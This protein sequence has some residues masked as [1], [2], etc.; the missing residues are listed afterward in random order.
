MFLTSRWMFYY[1]VE[2]DRFSGG[3]VMV[4]SVVATKPAQS[5]LKAIWQLDGTL[6]RNMSL[7]RLSTSLSTS[8]TYFFNK[9]TPGVI[10]GDAQWT[11]FTK[12]IS[13]RYLDPIQSRSLSNRVCTCVWQVKS[14][15]SNTSI[16]IRDSS[17]FASDTPG[18]VA[19]HF[20]GTNK[21]CNGYA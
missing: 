15:H 3:I 6:F 10:R 13:T 8:T 12:T 18:R 16:S 19:E 9:T 2:C 21:S 7:C 14:T 5:S 17:H 20:Y 1:M 11:I 4:G